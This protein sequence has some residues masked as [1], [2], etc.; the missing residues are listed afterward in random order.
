[1]QL[2]MPAALGLQLQ[3]EHPFPLFLGN[4]RG[5][6]ENSV[7]NTVKAEVNIHCVHHQGS[8]FVS[9]LTQMQKNY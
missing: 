4:P 1:M 3:Q 8:L 9:P 6:G 7:L 2:Q 5:K